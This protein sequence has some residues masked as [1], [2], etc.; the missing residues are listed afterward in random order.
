MKADQLNHQRMMDKKVEMLEQRADRLEVMLV[1][2]LEKLFELSSK[3][4]TH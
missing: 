3:Y 1:Q 2:T 4:E